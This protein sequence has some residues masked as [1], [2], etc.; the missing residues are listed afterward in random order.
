MNTVGIVSPGAMGSA[1]GHVLAAGGAK[2]VATLEQRSSRTAALAEGLELLPSLDAV[3]EASQVVLSI[4]PPGEALEVAASLADAAM[5]TGARPIVADLN[6]IAPSTMEAVAARLA[7]SGL[8][9]VD[10][11]I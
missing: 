6:A 4:V 1:V 9:A 7:S 5:R 3:V 2:V 8:E 11:S 10:G